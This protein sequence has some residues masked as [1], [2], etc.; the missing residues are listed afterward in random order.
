MEGQLAAVDRL[1]AKD[2]DGTL[3]GFVDQI[4]AAPRHAARRGSRSTSGTSS[5][6]PKSSRRCGCTGPAT[7][8]ALPE[9]ADSEPND[10]QPVGAG[11]AQRRR[12]RRQRAAHARPAARDGPRRPSCTR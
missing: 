6:P 7:I 4:L 5:T 12:H 1:Q 11:G 8:K 3:L 10:R 9:R 2:F